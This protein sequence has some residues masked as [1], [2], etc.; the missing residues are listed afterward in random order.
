[1]QFKIVKIHLEG[2]SKDLSFSIFIIFRKL[3]L[4]N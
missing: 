4:G 1:M 3:F 2:I